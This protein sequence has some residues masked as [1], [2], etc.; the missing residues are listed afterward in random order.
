MGTLVS[1]ALGMFQ[2][3]FAFKMPLR[4]PR[5]VHVGNEI[6]EFLLAGHKNCRV[7][8]RQCTCPS[9][10]LGKCLGFGTGQHPRWK[11]RIHLPPFEL[12]L[13]KAKL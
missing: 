10:R 2:N 12:I 9:A 6:P 3:I 1:V 4:I 7:I 11:S 5:E 8:K 13:G